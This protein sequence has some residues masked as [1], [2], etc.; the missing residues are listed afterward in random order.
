MMEVVVGTLIAMNDVLSSRP[1]DYWDTDATDAGDIKNFV[2]KLTLEDVTTDISEGSIC[3]S[4]HGK[5]YHH[6]GDLNPGCK[7]NFIYVCRRDFSGDR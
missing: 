7:R 5:F 3:F 4:R 2:Y 6:D 1:D